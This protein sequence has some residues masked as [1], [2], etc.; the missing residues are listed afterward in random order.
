MLT[1]VL[2]TQVSPG[3]AARR[4]GFG[5][6]PLS[7]PAITAFYEDHFNH[8]FI[9]LHFTVPVCVVVRGLTTTNNAI[10]HRIYVRATAVATQRPNGS[11]FEQFRTCCIRL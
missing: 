11:E 2:Q 7:R 3:P 4:L 5:H 8:E 9:P 10:M 6:D 1:I